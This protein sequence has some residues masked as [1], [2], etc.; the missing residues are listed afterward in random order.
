MTIKTN[1]I[2]SISIAQL[3]PINCTEKMDGKGVKNK[4]SN[5]SGLMGLTHTAI[6]AFLN[7]DLPDPLVGENAC[8]IRAAL[9]TD[10]AQDQEIVIELK[11]VCEMLEK[12]S[13]PLAKAVVGKTR[14]SLMDVLGENHLDLCIPQGIGSIVCS[15]LFGHILT[16][17][18]VSLLTIE[19]VEV[20]LKE[21]NDPKLLKGISTGFAKDLIKE[22]RKSLA[23]RSI[24]YLR[25]EACLLP[26]SP[27]IKSLIAIMETEVLSDPLGLQTA[28]LLAGMQI[29][30]A[31]MKK[32]HT[33]IVLKDRMI[34]VEGI[35]AG[36]VSMVF[37]PTGK[38]GEY[39]A[40]ENLS[41]VKKD[42]A[43]VIVEAVSISEKPCD[44]KQLAT[45]IIK[46]GIETII[47]ANC[48]AHPQYGGSNKG[49]EPPQTEERE[50]LKEIAL[51]EGLCDRNP[52]LCRI[53]HIYGRHLAK[54]A[55]C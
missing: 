14:S 19:K 49:V 4:L 3:M 21:S 15:I 55:L 34:D 47:L 33:P 5:Y 39:E 37:E 31:S 1:I 10:L 22:S 12:N 53:Y 41:A 24:K 30:L 48:A 35:D 44:N 51:Q 23:D 9:Y 54:E 16:V 20:S 52:K 8:Q 40:V 42:R 26:M 50:A 36:T 43:G 6:S 25:S 17:T 28:P 45:S 11:K 2:D 32:H 13:G 7:G 18:K 38:D 29:I 27:K 46:I